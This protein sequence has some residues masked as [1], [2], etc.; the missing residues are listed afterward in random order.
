MV[1]EKRLG[2][3]GLMQIQWT[4]ERSNMDVMIVKQFYNVLPVLL[5]KI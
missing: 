5:N 2:K 3:E 1:T 4:D